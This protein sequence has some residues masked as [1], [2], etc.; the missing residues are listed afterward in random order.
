MTQK[1]YEEGTF[2]PELDVALYTRAVLN[3]GEC[4]QDWATFT[5]VFRCN[6]QRAKEFGDELIWKGGSEQCGGKPSVR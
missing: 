3:P 4:N 1:E 2:L 6:P 5:Y